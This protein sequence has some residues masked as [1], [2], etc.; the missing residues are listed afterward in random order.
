MRL[1]FQHLKKCNSR[2]YKNIL[3]MDSSDEK[4]LIERVL[5]F[6]LRLSSGTNQKKKEKDVGA[7]NI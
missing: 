6:S 5:L 1:T 4:V 2:N 3:K 7:R